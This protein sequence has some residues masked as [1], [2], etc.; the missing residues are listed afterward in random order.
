[1]TYY[2]A[3]GWLIDTFNQGIQCNH[4]ELLVPITSRIKL[5]SSCKP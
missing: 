1:L 2:V 3:N 5:R 4:W